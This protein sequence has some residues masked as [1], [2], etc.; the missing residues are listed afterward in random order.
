MLF[1]KKLKEYSFKSC[2]S[3]SLLF[4]YENKFIEEFNTIVNN[5]CLN[6]LIIFNYKIIKNGDFMFKNFFGYVDSN[7]LFGDV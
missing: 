3:N 5:E 4:E 7:Y 6:D 1:M 2:T